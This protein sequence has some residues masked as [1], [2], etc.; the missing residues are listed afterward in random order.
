VRQLFEASLKGRV[1]RYLRGKA[2][3]II[4]T[5]F[6]SAASTECR[7]MF[8]GGHYYGCIS[9]VQSV[10]KGLAK[11]LARVNGLP[12]EYS[13]ERLGITQRNRVAELLRRGVI[14]AGGERAFLTITGTDRNRIHHMN[15]NVE[16]DSRRLDARAEECLNSLFEIESE[17]FAYT[18]SAGGALVPTH[19]QYWPKDE[20]GYFEAYIRMI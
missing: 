5:D 18:I 10:A 4:R 17:I 3:P 7:Q 14:S 13:A 2:H 15:K 20:N 12:A 1:E 16:T 19:P 8:T 9:V 11:F 6:F